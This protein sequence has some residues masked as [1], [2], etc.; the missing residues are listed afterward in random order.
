MMVDLRFVN[1]SVDFI[2]VY[3]W[4]SS[5]QASESVSRIRY[6]S[7]KLFGK[8]KSNDYVEHLISK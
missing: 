8:T 6:N 7:I 2:I 4:Y 1:N 5:V 3:I